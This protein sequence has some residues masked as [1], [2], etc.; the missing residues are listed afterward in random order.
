MKQIERLDNACGLIAW[1]HA[2]FNTDARHSTSGILAELLQTFQTQ[3]AQ[4]NGE[5]LA[6]HEE[7]H[8]IHVEFAELG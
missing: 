6:N 5:S 2:I 4:A 8:K 3:D 1:I 7:A